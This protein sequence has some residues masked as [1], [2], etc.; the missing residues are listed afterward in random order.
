MIAVYPLLY[1]IY[2]MLFLCM[3]GIELNL[4]KVTRQI[5]FMVSQIFCYILKYN[6]INYNFAYPNS[7]PTKM[8]NVK[9]IYYI[10]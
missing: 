10:L 7:K 1:M 6:D 5:N 3:F 2:Y 8:I 4:N 9:S